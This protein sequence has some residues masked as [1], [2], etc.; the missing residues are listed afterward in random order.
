MHILISKSLGY[1]S[2]LNFKKYLC[3]RV[4]FKG[5]EPQASMVC[6]GFILSH[7]YPPTHF[8]FKRGHD[9]KFFFFV[10]H[11]LVWSGLFQ[12]VF[13]VRTGHEHLNDSVIC[14]PSSQA[15]EQRSGGGGGGG[16]GGGRR[17]RRRGAGGGGGG[18]VFIEVLLV[19]HEASGS[20]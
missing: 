9:T 2:H 1:M 8:K 16:G 20:Y 13:H 15:N 19:L 12:L 4:E 10:R 17:R 11:L 18:G 3:N 14:T 7:M 6:S 5:K